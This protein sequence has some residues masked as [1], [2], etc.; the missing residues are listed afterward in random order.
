[1]EDNY[2][3]K[4]VV[5]LQGTFQIK[6]LKQ[7][8]VK[9]VIEQIKMVYWLATWGSLVQKVETLPLPPRLREVIV[10]EGKQMGLNWV[11][12]RYR[13][14][15]CKRVYSHLGQCHIH[16][17]RQHGVIHFPVQSCQFCGQGFLCKKSYEA[18]LEKE[19][20]RYTCKWCPDMGYRKVAFLNHLKNVHGLWET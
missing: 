6:T 4:A 2:G 13:C 1:M 5:D 12:G 14:K 19:H 7:V 20:P 3:C 16:E 18:H 17:Q 10:A 9:K 15:F 11:D 8:A